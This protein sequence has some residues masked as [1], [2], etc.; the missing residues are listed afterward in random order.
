MYTRNIVKQGRFLVVFEVRVPYVD[1]AYVVVEAADEKNV[2]SHHKKRVAPVAG[3]TSYSCCVC[4]KVSMTCQQN[5]LG[6]AQNGQ[7]MISTYSNH[8]LLDLSQPDYFI[9]FSANWDQL[10]KF[11]SGIYIFLSSQTQNRVSRKIGSWEMIGVTATN[12]SLSNHQPPLN[13]WPAWPWGLFLQ[14]YTPGTMLGF[15]QLLG[16][17]GNCVAFGR[18]KDLRDPY[19]RMG[20]VD[21]KWLKFEVQT[22]HGKSSSHLPPGSLAILRMSSGVCCPDPKL[23]LPSTSWDATSIFD[24]RLITMYRKP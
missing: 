19:V 15:E 20:G 18:P 13:H 14:T 10:V 2:R 3:K 21:Q 16:E 17:A 7:A 4:K 5:L 12:P 24:I 9:I 11:L 1:E 23:R 6:V 22:S 8:Y